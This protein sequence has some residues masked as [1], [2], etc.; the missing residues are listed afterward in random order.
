MPLEPEH[1][2]LPTKRQEERR[3]PHTSTF[4][5]VLEV[6]MRKPG[7]RHTVK[8]SEEVCGQRHFPLCGIL[9]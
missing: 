7:G 6:G 2:H 8:F 3:H 4:S 1:M 5:Y 9:Q